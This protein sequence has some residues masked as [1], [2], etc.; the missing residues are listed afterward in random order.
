MKEFLLLQEN[1]RQEKEKEK[2]QKQIT[3]KMTIVRSSDTNAR[4]QIFSH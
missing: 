4:I 1:A 3:E 2:K